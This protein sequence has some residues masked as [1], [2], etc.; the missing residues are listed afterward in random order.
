MPPFPLKSTYGAGQP[1]VIKATTAL[2]GSYVAGIISSFDEHN[3]VGLEITYVKGNETSLQIKVES[4]I[5]GGTTY[6]QQVT[7]SASGGTTTVVPNEYSFAAASMASTQIMTILINPIKG[8]HLKVSFKATGG[9]P[10]GT[11]AIRAIYGW[12]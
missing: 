5:D 7:Q 10:T 8:D 9:T 3:A 4:S 6:A 2:T 12:V 1:F 11:I